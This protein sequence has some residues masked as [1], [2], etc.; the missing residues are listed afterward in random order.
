MNT[1]SRMESTGKKNCIQI[2]D[3][4]ADLLIQSGKRKWITPREDKV[5]A[6]G[7]GEM[8]TWFVDLS[9]T[10]RRPSES[11]DSVES[12][13]NP[14]EGD[15][16]QF[17]QRDNV[18]FDG[19]TKRLIDW[20]VEV[21]LRLLRQIEAARQVQGKKNAGTK[22]PNESLLQPLVDK[23]VFDEVKEVV[24]LMPHSSKT[25]TVNVDTVM[26]STSVCEQLRDYV[27]NI[28]LLYR[29]NSVRGGCT[30][31]SIALMLCCA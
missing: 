24:T 18:A 19:K 16:E 14:R 7:K 23:T 6:K 4:T 22:K 20:N 9:A 17:K 26:L 13:T 29:N 11:G 28:A 2:S 30:K 31:K 10:G 8:T 12:T 27:E 1:A 15:A 3:Q 21:L 25:G 5:V